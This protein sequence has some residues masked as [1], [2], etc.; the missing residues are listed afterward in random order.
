MND[1]AVS[2]SIGSDLDSFCPPALRQRVTTLAPL[3]YRD[4]KRIAHRERLNL[5]SPNTLT[6]TSLIH[7]AFIKLHNQPGYETHG[8]FLRV[9]AVTMRHLL[10]DRVRAQLA[11]KR[12]G[13]AQHVELTEDTDVAVE[14]EDEDIVLSIHEALGKLAAFAPRLAE[15][16]QCRYFAG[17]TDAETAEALA[18]TERTVRR[19]WV[20]AKAWLARE[21]GDSPAIGGLETL[22]G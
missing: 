12:G 19:D 8:D 16:V 1:A 10:I 3:L 18:V 9:A 7:E 20:A 21:L 5:F 2:T 13:G 11:A 17:Y 22:A 4:L 15:V 14:V 6:T